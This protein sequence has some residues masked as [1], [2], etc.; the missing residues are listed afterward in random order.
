MRSALIGYSGFVGG[1]IASQTNFDDFYN[2]KNI[3]DIKGKTYDL[4]LSAGASSLVWKTNSQPEEDWENIKRLMDCLKETKAKRFILISTIMVYPN[5]FNVDEDTPI[6][7]A[8]NQ[9]YGLHRYKLEQF[10]KRNFKKYTIIRLPNLFGSGIKKNFI[11]DLIHNNHLD[12]THKDSTLQW[13]N[14]E[15]IYKDIQI[16][17]I[18][19]LPVVNFTAAPLSAKLIAKYC[20]NLKFTTI[21][22]K[23]PLNHNMLS[24]YAHLFNSKSL[25]FYSGKQTLKSLKDF[26]ISMKEKL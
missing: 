24:K 5:P 8:Q 19:N 13:Y 2:S 14:L 26:I 18:N 16:A 10:I 7:S 11:F 4:I 25:Y 22:N 6:S 15:N 9:P 20:L 12:L 17:V 1:N 3:E 21:T 23:P